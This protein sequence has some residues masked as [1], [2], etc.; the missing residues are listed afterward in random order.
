MSKR[1][2]RLL[3]GLVGAATVPMRP[4]RRAN[5]RLLVA[6][7]LYHRHRV[8]TRHGS[9]VFVST[10]PRALE[11]PREFYA[12]EPE[13][14]SWIDG[15]APGS[16]LWDIGA[17][18]GHYSLYA[19]RRGDIDV[20]A[21]EPSPASYAALCGN[22]AANNL[23]RVRAFCVALGERSG[24]GTL[25]MSQTYPGSVFNAFEQDVD[26][27]GAAL[28][29]E[30]RQAAIGLS[31]DDLAERFGAP[32]PN[33]IKLDVDSTE[34]AILRGAAIVLRSPALLSVLVENDAGDSDQ[35]RVI[36]AILVEAG[37]RAASR[38]RGGSDLTV[39]VIYRR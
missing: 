10:H 24:L 12:A 14:L 3:A 6:E 31:A 36:D 18:V 11:A 7:R 27:R 15:F 28:Q 22:I 1:A 5:L 35:N 25:N 26:M 29:I 39:N 30:R 9:L 21:F 19:G 13:T 32:L 33:H 4:W 17:N 2:A 23:T 37:F 34:A 20:L 8:E 16:V 38:G